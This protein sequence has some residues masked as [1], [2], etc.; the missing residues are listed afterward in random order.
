MADFRLTKFG[1]ACVRIEHR[2]VTVVVDPGGFTQREAVAGADV[3][4]VTHEHADHY[5]ADHLRASDAP[6]H[7]VEAV[8]AVIREQAPD[9]ADRVVVVEP[10]QRLDVGL[11]VTVVGERHAVIHED[12]PRVDNSG[13]LLD[14][15][16]T[17]VF[18]PGDALTVPEERVDVLLAPV[19]APWLKVGEA[20]D[21]VRAVA[22][23]RT[24]AIHDRVYSEVGLAMVEGHLTRLALGEGRTFTRLADGD[25]LA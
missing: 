20:V 11:P 16:G 14:L 21:F 4:L 3:V 19:S 9:L 15:D 8:A 1:H 24:V 7:T 18:H 13:Y 6:I 2:G 5:D 25:D 22:A 10:G 17:T 23:P 12:L